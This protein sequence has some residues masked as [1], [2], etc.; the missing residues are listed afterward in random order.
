MAEAGEADQTSA[1]VNWLLEAY[2]EDPEDALYAEDVACSTPTMEKPVDQDGE[3]KHILDGM[4]A[5]ATHLGLSPA[6]EGELQRILGDLGDVFRLEFG[7]D[8]PVDVEPLKVPLKEEAVPIKCALRRYPQAHMGGSAAYCHQESPGRISNDYHLSPDQRMDDPHALAD[9][10]LGRRD[11][12]GYWQLPVHPTCQMWYSFL[13]PF[14][15][16]T[17]TII[18]TGQADA[19][20]YYQSVVNEMFG[21]LLY[22]G[23][24]S[25]CG[26]F[27]LK[28]H[29]KKCDFF[30]KKATWCGKVI[31]AEGITHSP[32]RVHGLCALETPTSG[33]DLQQFVCATNWMRRSISSYSELI[34]ALRGL[35]D[36]AAKAVG[37]LK[38]TA[39]ARI[40][41]AT[42]GWASEHDACFVAVKDTL[43]QMVPLSHPSADKIICLYTDARDT[44][45]GAAC[46]QI[47]SEELEL[48]P[49]AFL[50]CGFDGASAR[51]LTVE[52]EAFAIC[53]RRVV[54]MTGVPAAPAAGIQTMARYQAR[55]LQRWAMV[56]TTLPYTVQHVAGEANVWA[57]LLSQW[58]AAS[59]PATVARVQQLVVVSLLQDKNFAWPTPAKILGIQ[60]AAWKAADKDVPNVTRSASDGYYVTVA[61]K[62][63]IPEVAEELQ[64]QGAA[65][66]RGVDATTQGSALNHQPADH[67]GDVA[68]VTAFQGLP[69][70]TTLAGF[71][72]PRTKEVLTKL[73][74]QVRDYREKKAHVHLAKF[75]LGDFVQHL[76]GP[77]ATSVHHASR[78]K[79][80]SDVALDVTHALVDYAEFG[81][82]GF[83][84]GLDE[85]ESS[86]EP[87]LQ[88]Y[89]D[90]A[91]V[92]RRCIVKNASDGVIKAMCDDLEVTLGHPL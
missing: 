72:H 47:P 43:R 54:Q 79:F 34:D 65:G 53:D 82:E 5:E 3:I 38:K 12:D 58:G 87:A 17:L 80:L 22:A 42:V 85:E 23:V 59:L 14:G 77:F 61:G 41:L 20:A 68:L 81:D 86:W 25:I 9:A 33:A 6:Q 84:K 1:N 13:T 27:H 18:L 21:G 26:K 64:Q 83:F 11:G 92:L 37:G 52:K 8:L 30:L 44:H 71:V 36:V 46:T 48:P 70:T 4:I 62:I 76:V 51:W 56:M 2:Q 63:W 89:E 88:L 19:M 60:K 31:S 39:L 55:K 16:Y 49:L 90:I 45:W 7:Q 91:V 10:K 40:K 69:S 73:Q 28:L 24:L 50:S 32:D 75:A 74:Q 57:D 35:L 29:P 15:V 67:L 66:R 78:L